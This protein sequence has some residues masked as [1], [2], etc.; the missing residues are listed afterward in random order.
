MTP[1]LLDFAVFQG[2][3]F[4]MKH[5]YKNYD[6]GHKNLLKNEYFF[7]Q[8]IWLNSCLFHHACLHCYLVS[9]CPMCI[10]WLIFSLIYMLS[11]FTFESSFKKWELRIAFAF[12]IYSLL[13]LTLEIFYTWIILWSRKFNHRGKKALLCHHSDHNKGD[14]VDILSLFS[15]K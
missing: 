9:F 12:R 8:K 13:N 10:I 4:M 7:F 5:Y 15:P 14:F 2:F 1:S 6:F 3:V 11:S